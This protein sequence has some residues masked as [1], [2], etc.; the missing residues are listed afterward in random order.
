MGNGC[1][2]NEHDVLLVMNVVR[3]D[4]TDRLMIMFSLDNHAQAKMIFAS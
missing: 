2:R 3:I 4:E 1:L